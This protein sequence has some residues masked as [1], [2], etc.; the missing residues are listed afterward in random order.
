MRLA[1][2]SR[3]GDFGVDVMHLNSAQNFFH[4]AWR[5][6]PRRGSGAG[7]RKNWKPFLPVPRLV[8]REGGQLALDHKQPQSIGRV[9]RV[10]GKFWCS[11]AGAGLYTG[12]TARAFAKPPKTPVTKRELTFASI[13]EDL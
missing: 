12:L 5:W 3:P 9:R 6:R 8:E 7:S 11:F 10:R 2:V 1:G 13:F 4:S